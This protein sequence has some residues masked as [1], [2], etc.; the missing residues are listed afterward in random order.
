MG[1]GGAN[2]C[3]PVG[4]DAIG[5]DGRLHQDVRSKAQI[6]NQLCLGFFESIRSPYVPKTS[7]NSSSNKAWRHHPGTEGIIGPG[8]VQDIKIRLPTQ[9][10]TPSSLWASLFDALFHS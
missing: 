4:V 7:H 10:L 5:V 9:N 1:V 6:C 2:T 8:E 3:Q